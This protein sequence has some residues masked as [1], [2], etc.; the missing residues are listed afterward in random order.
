MPM[1]HFSVVVLPAPL[2]PSSVPTSPSRT[3]KSMPCR[4]WDSPYQAFRFLTESRTSD[5]PCPKISLDHLRIGG[6]APVVAFGEDLATL[7]DGDAIRERRDHRKIVLGHQHGAVR[8]DAL[9][10]RGDALHVRVRHAGGRPVWPRPVPGRAGAGRA[11]R[12]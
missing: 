1:T 4:M 7:Q 3:S 9:D 6:H 12:R 2:R 11:L 5:M 8:R 10:E